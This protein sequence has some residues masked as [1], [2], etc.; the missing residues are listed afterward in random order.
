M[1]QLK[2]NAIRHTTATSD[3]ITLASDGTATAKITNNL[4]NRNLIING[5]MQVNQYGTSSTTASSRVCD[6][7]RVGW[8]GTDE[9][10]TYSKHALT[11]SDTGPWEKGFK[12]SLHIQNGNQTSGAGTGDYASINYRTEAQDI[13]NSGWVHTST[14][15]YLTFSFWVKSSVAQNFYVVIT[16][17][18]GTNYNY[19]VETGSLSANTWTKVTKTIP[20]NSNLTIDNDNGKGLEFDI[21]LFR[22]TD[23]TGSITLNQWAAT[24]NNTRCPDMTSTWWTTNDATFEITGVQ[25]E[26]GEV[27]TDFEHRSYAEDLARCQRYYYEHTNNFYG[28]NYSSSNKMVEIAHPV[29]M[30]V[31]PTETMTVG[32]GS[33]THFSET[34]MGFRAYA[35]SATDGSTVYFSKAVFSAEL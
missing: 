23:T 33:F 2:T 12:H 24:D 14:S 10:L 29:T 4:S 26:V 9:A 15:S 13:V 19:P 8:G 5:A 16:N 1:S 35:S 31:T 7:F 20:G 18:D 22:G 3:A 6:R 11:S 17:N 25:L 30:R 28:F 21:Q 34:N 27:A 32:G